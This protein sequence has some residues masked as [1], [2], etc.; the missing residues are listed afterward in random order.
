MISVSFAIYANSSRSSHPNG[1]NRDSDTGSTNSTG[2]ENGVTKTPNVQHQAV[3]DPATH[4]V[5]GPQPEPETVTPE[6]KNRVYPISTINEHEPTTPEASSSATQPVYDLA[7]SP[8][9]AITSPTPPNFSRQRS[10]TQRRRGSGASNLS[11]DSMKDGRG[12]KIG[13]ARPIGGVIYNVSTS[14]AATSSSDEGT[15]GSGVD[16]GR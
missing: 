5:P 12:I 11:M 10:S 16:G 3:E 13:A 1:D 15:K 6:R 9:P 7:E 14:N 4:V 2:I 8:L